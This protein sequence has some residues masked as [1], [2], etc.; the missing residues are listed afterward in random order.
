M[1]KKISV[2]MFPCDIHEM[3]NI[4]NS[5]SSKYTGELHTAGSEEYLTVLNLRPCIYAD[6]V[7]FIR[8]GREVSRP[9]YLLW[10]S[11]PIPN[12]SMEICHLQHRIRRAAFHTYLW[13]GRKVI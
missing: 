8:Q 9:Q 12:S 13:I 6:L 11:E 7:T 5:L 3:N 2:L 1:K 10:G 4:T